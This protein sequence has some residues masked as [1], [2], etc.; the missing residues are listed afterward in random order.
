MKKSLLFLLL[1]AGLI[2]S[3]SMAQPIPNADFAAYQ[4]ARQGLVVLANPG[5]RLPLQRLDTLRP[6]LATL[7]LPDDRV[8]W[9]A[10]NAYQP[11][12]RLASNGRGGI[13]QQNPGP[14]WPESQPYNCLI[15][16]V[17]IAAVAAAKPIALPLEAL[18][19]TRVPT[20]WLLF[21]G[22]DL[23]PGMQ[24]ID[25]TAAVW[26]AGADAWSQ[27]LAAQALYG[28]QAF[29]NKLAETLSAD[30]PA[31]FGLSLPKTRLGYAPPEA[32]GFN[33]AL[34]RD[35]IAAVVEEGRAAGAYPGAQVLVARHGLVVYHQAFGRH[36]YAPD[37][38]P[39]ALADIYDLASITKITSCLPVFMRLYGQ[40]RFNLDGRLGDALPPN[41][42][43]SNKADL[44]FRDLLTHQARL[45]A[46]I[47]YWR[48]TL[49]G[50]ARYPWQKK[51]D[52]NRANDF[53]FRPHT[54]SPDSS[55]A[56]PIKIADGLWR[57]RNF[58]RQVYR[59]ILK[60]PLDPKGGYVYSDLFFTLAPQVVGAITGQFDLPAY[61]RDTLYRPLG[62]Y[63]IGYNPYRR[64]PLSRIVP[65]E[66]D[67]FFRM[68]QLY[69]RVHDE[70]A[71]LLDGISGHAGL[72]ATAADLA[73]I[74]QLYL[75]RG[76]YGGDTLIAPAAVDEFTRYQFQNQANHRGLG[77]DKPMP[78]PEPRSIPS[79][80][81]GPASFG[82]SGYTGTFTW[83]DPG[84]GTLFIFL[85]NRVHPTRDN[86]LISKLNLRTR[87]HDIIYKAAN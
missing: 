16:A 52:P 2:S 67:T 54:L 62:A 53:R 27:S 22:A 82:H 15:L 41:M 4:Q 79:R 8:L 71:A 85:S 56:F 87:V 34:L 68:T 51:W 57:H 20:I 64:F 81:A 28:G 42:A 30:Y 83:A 18:D 32:A 9:E 45:R 37:A 38:P 33:A 12:A 11:V 73:K 43:K 29:D 13:Q 74:M 60:S 50:N 46:W 24:L 80:S 14:E 66:R 59:A 40:G 84:N 39:V 65:T 78:G 26:L 61:L 21:N 6:A 86:T 70:G 58:H 77:F 75:N 48:G 69:G 19:L 72:F 5:G 17:D 36:T 7:G 55:A 47:P 3:A 1:M 44:I 35:S 31:G 10:L 63:S 23:P 25:Q 49:R 76:V